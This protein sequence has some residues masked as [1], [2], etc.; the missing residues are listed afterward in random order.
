ME[1]TQKSTPVTLLHDHLAA[2]MDAVNNVIVARMQSDIALIPRLAGYLI[3]AGGKRM[4]PL[5]TLAAA[6]LYTDDITPTHNLAA[7]VEFIH[8]A[9]LLHDDVVDDSSLRRGQASANNLFGN[10]SSVL[11]G[12]FLFARAFELMVES[13]SLDVLRTLSRASAIIAE[14]EILQ[15]SL[16]GQIDTHINDYLR[17]IG[18]KTAALFAAASEIGPMM[19]GQDEAQCKAL[20]AYGYNLGMAFQIADD[21]LDITAANDLGKNFGDDLREGKMTAPFIF[22]LE[23]TEGAEREKLTSLLTSEDITEQDITL[24]TE[25]LEQTDSLS[26]TRALA[27]NYVDEAEKALMAAPNTELRNHLIALAHFALTRGN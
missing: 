19:T 8:T 23:K 6:K 24:A 17:V 9:T 14:G 21:V 26:R 12:D 20:A 3:A 11:V 7:A 18:A 13:R 5:M 22:A 15:L 2:D 4:R 27:K 16:Q 25:I 1:K 10:A